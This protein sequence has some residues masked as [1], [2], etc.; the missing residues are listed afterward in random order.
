MAGAPSY[1]IRSTYL[2]KKQFH[3]AISGS[4]WAPE[5]FR[6][7]KGLAGQTLRNIPLSD[8]ERYKVGML[9]LTKGFDTAVGYVKHIERARERQRWSMITYGF[10]TKESESQFAYCPQL[11]CRSDAS[12]GERLHIFKE[13]R[14]TLAETNGRVVVSTE[15][16]LNGEYRPT[17]IR[18]NTVTEDFSRPLRI[19]M[20]ER[21]IRDGPEPPYRPWL[22]AQEKPQSTKVRHRRSR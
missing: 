17:N 18:E 22:K 14:N 4:R 3:Y 9:F 13:I 16:D 19:P 1:F 21:L 6:A 12:V 2:M 15:C 11:Y 5:S 7:S 20:G 8:E 10:R